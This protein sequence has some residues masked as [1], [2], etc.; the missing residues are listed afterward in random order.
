MACFGKGSG[1]RNRPRSP[2][3]Q[4]PRVRPSH[5][6]G[7]SLIMDSSA[8]RSARCIQR[9]RKRFQG[10]TSPSSDRLM[11]PPSIG[12]MQ[13]GTWRTIFHES[14]RRSLLILLSSRLCPMHRP[15]KLAA[16]SIIRNPPTNHWRFVQSQSRMLFDQY[17]SISGNLRFLGSTILDCVISKEDDGSQVER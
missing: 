16:G 11:W 15:H 13:A 5:L 14:G 10:W 12:S 6:L 9:A 3:A 8:D 4:L 7:C 17:N 1:S 2:Q